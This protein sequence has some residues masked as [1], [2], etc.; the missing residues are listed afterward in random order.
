MFLYNTFRALII[1]FFFFNEVCD[2][3]FCVWGLNTTRVYGTIQQYMYRPMHEKAGG[4]KNV[5][6]ISK[7]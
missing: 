6:N 2:F 5:K 1:F 4:T 3:C 7:R